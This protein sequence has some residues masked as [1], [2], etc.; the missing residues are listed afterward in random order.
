MLTSA[1]MR[2]AARSVAAVL[3]GVVAAGVIV[4][5]LEAI[6]ARLF[7]LPEGIDA[8]DM[9]AMRR[10]VAA[11]PQSAF[12]LLLAGWGIGT[13]MGAWIAARLAPKAPRVHG[14]IVTAVLLAAGVAN[15]VML[16]HPAWVWV[17]G[18]LLFVTGGC[19]GTHLAL[20]SLKTPQPDRRASVV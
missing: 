7:N 10:A 20:R 1:A 11:L 17:V 6:N 4:A 5:A 15:M 18:I 16:P 8:S 3:A 13:L 2:K 9:E 19:A 12:I 14:A